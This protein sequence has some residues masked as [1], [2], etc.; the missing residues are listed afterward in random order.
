MTQKTLPPFGSVF[1]EKMPF[2][3]YDGQKWSSWQWQPSHQLMM[4]PAMHVLHYGSACFEGIKAF[5]QA[6][7]RIVIFRLDKHVQR[8]RQSASL[9]NLP[10]PEEALVRE[11]IMA[12]VAAARDEIPE[13]PA[14]L[15][16]RPTLFGTDANVGKAGVGS[17]SAYFYVLVSPVGDYFQVGSP[18][19]LYVERHHARCAPHM[20]RVKSG[21]N[22]AS[23]LMWQTMAK[24][25]HGA[26]Q[27]LFCPNDDVQETGASNFFMIDGQ[28]LITK[29]LSEA[30]LHGVTR[31]SVLQMAP[32]L[33][34][35]V[36]ER[37]FTV[38][39]ML[40]VIRRGGE[41]ALT[42]TAA[43]IAPVTS[44]VVDG[45]EIQVQKQELALKLRQALTAIQYGDAPDV[46]AWLTELA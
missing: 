44:F 32:R 36:E 46:E 15:Y 26:N 3:Q 14:A 35:K 21:G 42:G 25:E 30:F 8:L 43:V 10:V 18:M 22:Y 34:L 31:D 23:A 37:D 24:R 41:A 2:S 20:G 39:E 17:E 19:K 29:A 6:N 27:V 33:G 45:Q 9:L 40:D 12:A 4:H 13:A 11:M 16:I 7:G 28:T 38:S 5:R 1:H